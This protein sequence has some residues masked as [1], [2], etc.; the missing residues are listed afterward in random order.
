VVNLWD[1]IS[2]RAKFTKNFSQKKLSLT[3]W[4]EEGAWNLFTKITSY[5]VLWI[6]SMANVFLLL[7]GDIQG[8]YG[9]VHKMWIKRFNHIRNTIELTRNTPKTYDKWETCKQ[10]S[11]KALVYLCEHLSVIKFFAIHVE[12]MKVYTLWWNGGT[13]W[14]MLD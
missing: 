12:T 7:G 11:M 2:W 6:P 13:L 4:M 5:G 8:G 3:P 9:V 14:E 1:E 10:H